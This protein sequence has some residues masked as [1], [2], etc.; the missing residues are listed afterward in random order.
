MH[1]TRQ[2]FASTIPPPKSQF[3]L[4]YLGFQTK[5]FLVLALYPFS[6]KSHFGHVCS[7]LESM[8]M[9]VVC[10]ARDELRRGMGALKGAD[11]SR[12]PVKRAGGPCTAHAVGSPKLSGDR[13]PEPKPAQSK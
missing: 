10:D 2:V 9:T 3:L 8:F 5:T 7:G 1:R 13:T 12:T 6:F 11:E 4:I